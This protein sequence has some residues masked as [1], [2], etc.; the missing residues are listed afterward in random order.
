MI[1]VGD[2]VN[3]PKHGR[4]QLMRF[5]EGKAVVFFYNTEREKLV[6]PKE[7]KNAE[8]GIGGSDEALRG[9]PLF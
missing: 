4:G 2:I 5:R 9:L 8:S 3:H 6:D 1:E 7:L